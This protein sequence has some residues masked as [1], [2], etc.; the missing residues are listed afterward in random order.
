MATL[1]NYW[2]SGTSHRTRIA[3]AL[4]GVAYE[5]VAIDLTASAQ[6]DPDF[7]ARNPQGLVPAFV[8]DDGETLTQSMAIIEWLEETHP[9]PPLL[10]RD[11]VA[12]AKV[13]AIA[14][15]V[16]CDI[17]PLGNLRVLQYLRKEYGQDE[18]GVAAWSTRWIRDGF[19][20][21]EQMLAD[22]PGGPWCWGTEPTLADVCL[23]PQIYAAVSRYAL[24][25]RHWRRLAEIDMAAAAHPAFQIAHPT[26]Q[27]DAR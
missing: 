1:F 7:L 18:A 12:R 10:P 20:A 5:Q 2:R 17:H 24:D 14:N 16:A 4:K 9:A 25:I 6:R 26:R 19:N 8:T 23:V 15:A 13:R 11:P 22:S 3:L 27:P 21:I